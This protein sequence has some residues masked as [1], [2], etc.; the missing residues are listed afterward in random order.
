MGHRPYAIAF[1]GVQFE[2]G[3][4]LPWDAEPHSGEIDEWWA[5][6]AGIE[7]PA[8]HAQESEWA[9]YFDQKRAYLKGNPVPVLL[10]YQGSDDCPSSIVACAIVRADWDG[11]VKLDLPE[12]TDE[13][14]SA[15]V[16]FLNTYCQPGE[17]DEPPNFESLGWQL[18]AYY[19]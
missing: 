5:A 18:A 6:R 10:E 2:E 7:Q 11:T 16:E 19:G 12:V 17:H 15:L 4:S 14:R 8:E 13:Q 3:Y 9:V 1:Y